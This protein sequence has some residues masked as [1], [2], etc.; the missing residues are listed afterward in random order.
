MFKINVLR[1]RI[2]HMIITEIKKIYKRLTDLIL[3]FYI[4]KLNS[5][6][7]FE[8]IHRFSYWK[9]PE[10]ESLSGA[11]SELQVTENIRRDLSNFLSNYQ[12][13]TILDAPCGDFYWMSKMN[14]DN[15]KY[16]GGD[17]VEKLIIDNNNNF[18]TDNI[19][20]INLDLT[21][22][23]IKYYDIIFTRDC[24]VHLNNKE[25]FEVIKNIKNSKSK[26]F[27]STIFEKNYNN[28]ESTL[29]D[30]WRP[31]NLKMPPF[32]FPKIFCLLNDSSQTINKCD[33]YKK[34]AVWKVEDL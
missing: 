1:K 24:L 28:N 10:S 27:A 29:N 9:S 15:L 21:K 7:R 5:K 18:K 17:I 11:G 14:L 22:S 25:I 16:T 23:E 32:N 4:K 26:F 33:Y 2:I 12:I 19:N 3:G 8:T 31:I 6:K 34:I 30:F 13:K 20:F